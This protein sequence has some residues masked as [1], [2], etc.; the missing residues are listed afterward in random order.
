MNGFVQVT[1][2]CRHEHLETFVSSGMAHRDLKP[3]NVLCA[4]AGQLTPLKICDFDL[5]SGIMMDSKDT[6]PVT[7]PELQ[8][9]VGT[10]I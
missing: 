4:R 6:T 8:T 9:P 10:G 3:E 5:G 7:T 2:L 1:L